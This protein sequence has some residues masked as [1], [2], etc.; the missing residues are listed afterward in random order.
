MNDE[1]Q[2]EG[3]LR[4]RSIGRAPPAV[5][6]ALVP[7]VGVR[8]TERAEGLLQSSSR[9]HPE[10]RGSPVKSKADNRLQ[11]LVTLFGSLA[12]VSIAAAEF[13]AD[14]LPSWALTALKIAAILCLAV[15]PVL[16]FVEGWRSNWVRVSGRTAFAIAT[17]ALC[18]AGLAIGSLL[19]SPVGRSSAATGSPGYATR[20]DAIFATLRRA[21]TEGVTHFERA[22]GSAAEG[23]AAAQLGDAFS[24]A[25]KE[26]RAAATPDEDAS[27]GRLLGRRLAAVGDAYLKLR[28]TIT[29]PRRTRV[30][31]KQAQARLDRSL[32]R[33]TRT[34]GRLRTHGYRFRQPKGTGD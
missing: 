19:P 7:L 15:I 27:L 20:L 25:A 8:A 4:V 2:A 5:Y 34:E 33:L 31:L 18:G 24:R 9:S 6:L 28:H 26:V 32:R 12:G 1:R 29:S 22:H 21:E 11:W 30:K 17:V 3:D 16:I 13:G 23:K 10:R 14:T